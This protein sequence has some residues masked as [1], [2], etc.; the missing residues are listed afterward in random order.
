MWEDILQDNKTINIGIGI[1][2]DGGGTFLHAI[3]QRI[4]INYRKF[5]TLDKTVEINGRTINDFKYFIGLNQAQ[6]KL[7]IIGKKSALIC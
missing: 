2:L 5:I 7:L 3:E 4:K 1:G 6:L